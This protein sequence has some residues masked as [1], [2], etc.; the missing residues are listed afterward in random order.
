MSQACAAFRIQLEETLVGRPD[1][2]PLASLSWHEHLRQC[3]DCRELLEGEQALELLLATLPEPKLPPELT[4]RIL[5]R[6]RQERGLDRLDHLLELDQAPKAPRDLA[7]RILARLASERAPEQRAEARLDQLLDLVWRESAVPVGLSA[8]LRRHLAVARG[9]HAQP[10]AVPQAPPLGRFRRLASQKLVR[11]AA[12]V[13]LLI[14]LAFLLPWKWMRGERDSERLAEHAAPDAS[15]HAA[16]VAQPSSLVQPPL[17]EVSDDLL[18]SL[19]VLESWEAL[20]AAGA[21]EGGG[22]ADFDPADLL[23][24]ELLAEAEFGGDSREER[25]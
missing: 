21:T 4:S 5:Q 3:S 11:L 15:T 23:V 18:A 2:G 17:A 8:R 12:G 7:Q 1:R 9:L 16:V 25:R 19:D 13:L 22:F 14:S 6:L 24:L 20:E 10:E